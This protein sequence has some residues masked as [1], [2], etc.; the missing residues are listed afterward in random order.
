ML[1]AILL[2]DAFGLQIKFPALDDKEG[3]REL[4]DG[5]AAKSENGVFQHVVGAIDGLLLELA[6]IRMTDSPGAGRYYTQYSSYALNVQAIT[7]SH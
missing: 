6:Y 2:S 7:D 3:L 1:E 4:A 5:F